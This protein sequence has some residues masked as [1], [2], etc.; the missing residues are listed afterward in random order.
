[1]N[2]R[3]GIAI[4]LTATSWLFADRF[5]VSPTPL[6][7]W[8]LLGGS[9][10]LFGS[11]IR[12]D[13]RP[14]RAWGAILAGLLIPTLFWLPDPHRTGAWFL[15]AGIAVSGI[16]RTELGARLGRGLLAVGAIVLLQAPVVEIYVAWS[17]RNP[18]ISGLSPLIAW[19]LNGIGFS[20]GA[21][22]NS[23]VIE[24][25]KY[26]HTV[27]LTWNHLA[28]L[29]AC[30]VM[31]GTIGW[32]VLAQSQRIVRIVGA[33]LVVT[34]AYVVVRFLAIL[35][36]FMS[37][38]LR[39]EFGSDSVHVPWFWLPSVVFASYLPL[40]LFLAR[41]LNQTV[42]PS[43]IAPQ[44]W[45]IWRPVAL[46]IALT[47]GS[48]LWIH[49]PLAG[50]RKPG[51]VLIENS[52]GDWERADRP[53]T[54]DWY[55]AESG[56]NYGVLAD[57]LSRHYD[58]SLHS[59]GE[60]DRS[61]LDDV[62]VLILKT[63]SQP[64]SESEIQ[65]IHEFVEQ[66][67]GLFVL[68]EHTNVWGST[69]HFNPVLEPY[70]ISLRSDCVFDIERKWE[71]LYWSPKAGRHPIASRVP[72]YLF[73]V[74]CSI[75]S[76]WWAR[77]AM[78]GKGLWTLP[79]TYSVGNFYPQVLDRTEAHF[80]SFDQLVTTTF[81]SGRVVV[82]SDSTTFSNFD[83]GDPGKLDLILDTVEWLNHKNGLE[84]LR[85]VGLVIALLALAVFLYGG[86]RRR[87][88]PRH[89]LI[90]IAASTSFYWFGVFGSDALSQS[91]YERPAPH[92][93]A[94]SVVFDLGHTDIELPIF[95]FSQDFR[96][97]YET[98]HIATLR[99]GC[100]PRVDFDFPA[101]LTPSEIGVVLVPT[102][103]Y[104]QDEL[105]QLRDHVQSGGRLLVLDRYH[106]DGESSANSIVSQFGLR[107]GDSRS[108]G[109]S[110]TASPQGRSIC[111]LSGGNSYH[112]SRGS[113]SV[114]GGSPL[115][116][117]ESGVPVAA[118]TS[119]GRGLVIAAG[120]AEIFANPTMG[121]HSTVPDEDTRAIYEVEF[122]L[123]RALDSREVESTFRQL[124][125]AYDPR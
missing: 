107:F 58:V 6:A 102:R 31:V 7:Q 19:L 42:S 72:F 93:P 88:T 43:A 46:G 104:T 91:V 122:T 60:L 100:F 94:Q 47:L 36:L 125:E 121:S 84:S 70:E 99:T 21:H 20:A 25:L 98:F 123:L 79:A 28:A 75:D 5:F 97:S 51:R 3:I 17:A 89:W 86:V 120:F 8:V 33:A 71:Q 10:W 117:A 2:T 78:R 44:T 18:E 76:S 48:L 35:A 4:T 30:L 27:E 49:V 55:G 37:T 13:L 11:A 23:V 15:L 119:F 22:E 56:Y 118:W 114:H 41:C 108:D 109:E 74:S 95:G 103:A 34:T 87:V 14:T 64:Y 45:P 81:G 26:N 62:D 83:V 29:P 16:R 73:A 52:K 82:F 54:S 24:S 67:G 12:S 68:G 65:A 9:A 111:T 59:D 39:V 40:S 32:C 112:P 63:V 92:E 105:D 110:I 101:S 113:I 77:S 1:M 85:V 90:T 50:P 116:F 66:G 106:E 96:N 61:A 115:L 124:E 53:Y 38:M 57:Y 80:G 69:T